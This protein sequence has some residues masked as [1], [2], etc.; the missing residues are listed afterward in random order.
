MDN[1]DRKK[2]AS[3][4]RQHLN[5]YGVCLLHLKLDFIFQL[6]NYSYNLNNR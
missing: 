5:N 2:T 1:Q 3:G 6:E 4:Q